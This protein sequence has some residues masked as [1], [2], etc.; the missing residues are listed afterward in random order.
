[1]ATN[2]LILGA[3]A[4]NH[5]DFPLAYDIV[6]YYRSGSDSIA[7]HLQALGLDRSR[8]ERFISRLLSSGCTS[9]DQFADYLNDPDD[10]FMAKALLAY[11]I[12]A[13]ENRNVLSQKW[14]HGPWYEVLA[15]QLI[16]RGLDEFPLR[17]I[18]I[19]TFNYDRSLE[20]Y[21]L[22]CLASRFLGPRTLEQIEDAFR[23]LKIIHIYGCLGY[24][25]R[26]ARQTGEPEREY[27]PIGERSQLDLAIDGM[28]LLRELRDNPNLGDRQAAQDCV[29]A[30]TANITFLGFAYSAENLEALALATNST[31]GRLFGTVLGISEGEPRAELNMRMQRLCGG[32][33][34]SAWECDVFEAFRLHPTTILGQPRTSNPQNSV[35]H[36]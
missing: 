12:G 32:P 34:S 27:R 9:I 3:G 14:A 30:A 19:V 25:P 17:D 22:D 29:R 7:P 10:I 5:Y 16:G 35:I 31:R 13:R 2:V 21:M 6:Q 33:L 28:H 24:L 1:M 18:A 8:F 4:S 23:R 26:F 11:H 36:A 20:R 15:N